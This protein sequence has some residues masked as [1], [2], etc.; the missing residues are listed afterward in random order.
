MSAQH[1]SQTRKAGTMSNIL[2][3]NEISVFKELDKEDVEVFLHS[4]ILE[5]FLTSIDPELKV[6]GLEIQSLDV[7]GPATNR[8]VLFAKVKATVLDS[9]GNL[10][11]GI[12][13][14]RGDSVGILMVVKCLGEE[15]HTI[16]TVQP[17]FPVGKHAFEEIPAG[18]M[19]D[20]ANF[21]GVAAKELQ[22]EVGIEVSRESLM[23]LGNVCLSPGG[24]DER[25]ALFAFEMDATK[26]ELDQL[27][28][29]YRGE[30]E[31]G[32]NITLKVMPLKNVMDLDDAKSI[33]AY[34]KYQ[35][36]KGTN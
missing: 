31:E 6:K 7:I 15:D 26:E 20:K 14:L 11:P 16:L 35:Q 32:E 23:Y 24:C 9:A 22:E 17:R 33:V 8:R 18:M 10:I 28:G 30:R 27:N 1:E 2:D 21:A 5:H 19:D 29:Q 25:M 13:F 12:A 34:A 4:H 36:L 3:R